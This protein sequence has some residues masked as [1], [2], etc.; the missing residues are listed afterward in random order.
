MGDNDLCDYLQTDEAEDSSDDGTKEL[1]ERAELLL[2]CYNIVENEIAL[3]YLPLTAEE[4][5]DGGAEKISYTSFLHSPVS[6]L[7]VT[8]ERGNKVPYS[9]FPEYIRTN[10]EKTVVVTYSYAPERK[11]LSGQTDY[12]ARIPDRLFAYGVVCEACIIRGLY[13]EA[14]LWD[15][16][17]K[18]ALLCVYSRNRPRV[19]RSRRWV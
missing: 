4:R 3:D 8:D 17:Y 2:R 1:T 16:K 18:D 12:G 19:I 10:G 7:S 13:D 6:I 15:K 14:A 9:V 5:I 11:A